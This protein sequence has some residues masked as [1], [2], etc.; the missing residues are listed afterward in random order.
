MIRYTKRTVA[1][2]GRIKPVEHLRAYTFFKCTPHLVVL[3]VPD[4][5]T[6]QL[7][8][9]GYRRV[10]ADPTEVSLDMKDVCAYRRLRS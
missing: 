2:I 1:L 8:K 9:E 5:E 10:I 3:V 6:N 4:T 7:V